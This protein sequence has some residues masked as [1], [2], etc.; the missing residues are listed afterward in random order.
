MLGGTGTG[1]KRILPA[2]LG[3][4]RCRVTVVQG[5][6]PERLAEVTAA[7]GIR[8]TTDIEEFAALHDEYDLVY[9]GSPPFLRVPH[10]ALAARL[11]KPILCEK[12][13]AVDP[14]QLEE[15]T[16]TVIRAGVPLAV[17]HQVRHQPAIAEIVRILDEGSIGTL[18]DA[19]LQWNF[20]M[21]T[22]APNAV[23]KLDP[24]HAGSSSMFDSGV[25]LVDL[26]LL[27]FGSPRAVCAL[28]QHRMNSRHIDSVTA[29]LDYLTHTVTVTTSQ[30]SS[31][32]ANDLVVT[33][34][35]GLLLAPSIF[36]E[37]PLTELWLRWAGGAT[38]RRFPASNLYRAMVEDFCGRLDGAT[39][40]GTGMSDAVATSK[41]L[42]AIEAA[43][44]DRRIVTVR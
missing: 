15:I 26:A 6:D 44:A 41:V 16:A 39:A 5:R 22:K 9:I 40:V 21:N 20:P 19:H 13:L 29:V 11:R 38:T 18:R 12:P 32:A 33:G 7:G 28:G 34:T 3:S 25:H 4:R 27:L 36:G 1:R 35:N 43:I 23:W 2:C 30:V 8:P 31:S 10:I 14:D 37:Q 24:D 17:A 42:F